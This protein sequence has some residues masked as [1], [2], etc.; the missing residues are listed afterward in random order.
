MTKQEAVHAMQNGKKVTHRYLSS[1]RYFSSNEWVTM[2]GP[3]TILFE[4]G[5]KCSVIEFWNDRTGA[6]WQTG[7][8]IF[9]SPKD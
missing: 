3:Y 2:I 5:V 1:N 6:G 4:D 7:W 8:N 9:E